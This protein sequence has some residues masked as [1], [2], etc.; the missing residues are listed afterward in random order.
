MGS[1]SEYCKL[2]AL[3]IDNNGEWMPSMLHKMAG[4]NLG[5][6]EVLINILRLGDKIDPVPRNSGLQAI[7]LLDKFQIYGKQIC[8]LH[9]DLCG[10]DIVK[11]TA[12]IKAAQMELNDFTSEAL[13]Q[14]LQF[15]DQGIQILIDS[16]VILET[17][18]EKSPEFGVS[19]KAEEKRL[20]SEQKEML[21]YKQ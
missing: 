5:A 13:K 6:I 17:I 19:Y 11:T 18:Q 1:I 14:S 21:K 20:I 10:E 9:K 7:L 4:R 2:D 12:L 8:I 3:Q 15:V 16:D